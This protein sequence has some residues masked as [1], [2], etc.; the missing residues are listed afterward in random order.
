MPDYKQPKKLPVE[1]GSGYPQDD[2]DMEGIWVKGKRES[3]AKKI[4][5]K[6]MRGYGAAERG[7]KF[8]DL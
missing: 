3:G 2:I 7:R 1:K 4:R 8:R 5:R 6:E